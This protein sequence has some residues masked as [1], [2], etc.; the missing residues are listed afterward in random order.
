MRFIKLFN[1]PGPQGDPEILDF[2]RNISPIISRI[3]E[4]QVSTFLTYYI[5]S[6]ELGRI[7]DGDLRLQDLYRHLNLLLQ[8]EFIIQHLTIYVTA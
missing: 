3:S 1:G 6:T 2:I 5:I 4:I 7:L 8:I